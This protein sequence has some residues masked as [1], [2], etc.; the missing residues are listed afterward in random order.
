MMCEED[1]V[2]KGSS[3]SSTGGPNLISGLLRQ[4]DVGGV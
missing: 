4:P 1:V 3:Q 2:S